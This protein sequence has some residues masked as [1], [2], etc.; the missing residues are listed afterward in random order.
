MTSPSPLVLPFKLIWLY[1][2]WFGHLKVIM[3]DLHRL[4]VTWVDVDPSLTKPNQSNYFN[5]RVV[6][7]LHGIFFYFRLLHLLIHHYV[8]GFDPAQIQ[9]YLIFF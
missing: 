1:F 9:L 5:H 8:S 4:L 7:L 2:M 3:L 6:T